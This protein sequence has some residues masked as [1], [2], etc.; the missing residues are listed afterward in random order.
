MLVLVGGKMR[1]LSE[2]RPLAAGAG[3]SVRAAARQPS[4]RFLV[5]CRPVA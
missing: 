3:L 5:E 1:T 4:G 2:L